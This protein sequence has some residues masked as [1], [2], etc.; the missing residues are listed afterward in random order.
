[1]R[2]A[3]GDRAGEGPDESQGVSSRDLQRDAPAKP[4]RHSRRCL[5]AAG[6]QPRSL[7][8]LGRGGGGPTDSRVRRGGPWWSPG[9]SRRQVCPTP[10]GTI[11][12]P[13]TPISPS[14]GGCTEADRG[15]TSS[16]SAVTLGSCFGELLHTSLL[17][18]LCGASAGQEAQVRPGSGE[19]GQA[20]LENRLPGGMCPGLVHVVLSEPQSPLL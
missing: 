17:L 19:K 3:W 5:G 2:Q 13:Q 15:M 16:R 12:A 1:M 7:G 11:P 14:S 6:W 18:R 9:A 20:D 8:V 4:H 10:P